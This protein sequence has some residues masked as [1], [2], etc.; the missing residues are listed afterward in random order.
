MEE[1]SSRKRIN[2]VLIWLALLGIVLGALMG[3]AFVT[4]INATLLCLSCVGIQ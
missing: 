2:R 4:W 1:M 3:Q